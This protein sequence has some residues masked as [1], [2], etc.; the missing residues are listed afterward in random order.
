[1]MKRPSPSVDQD[2]T[3]PKRQKISARKHRSLQHR[4]P[5]A[6]LVA[7]NPQD[8]A[9]VDDLLSRALCVALH[10]Q[11]FHGVK[12]DAFESFR[13]L[14][15]TYLQHMSFRVKQSMQSSRRQQPIPQ[16]FANTLADFNVR[17]SS[18][19]PELR[20]PS[21]PSLLTQPPILPAAHTTSTAP[22]FAAVLPIDPSDA[23]AKRATS[24][25]PKHFPAFPGRHTYKSTPVMTERE[26]DARRI[27]EL[28]TAEGKLAEAALRKLVAAKQKALQKPGTG[29]RGRQLS[30]R[31]KENEDVWRDTMKALMK[32]GGSEQTDLDRS[33]PTWF[34]GAADERPSKEDI[35]VDSV[36]NTVVN[37]DRVHWRSSARKEALGAL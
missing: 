14:V 8:P 21:F 28:A 18:L 29:M 15:D 17:P 37:Y 1:M 24:Y 20:A 36:Y 35:D 26:K 2:E 25:I 23:T 27:R 32:E 4:Q 10:A 6:V 9:V 11:G 7:A 5:G 22:E 12:K 33:D 31:E 34:D 30:Q 13:G 19:T 16:D 3:A